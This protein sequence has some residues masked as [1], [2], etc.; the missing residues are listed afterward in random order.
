[1]KASKNCNV[2]GELSKYTGELS[3]N[4]QVNI[5]ARWSF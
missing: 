4:L 3:N 5:G 1:V 2:Y